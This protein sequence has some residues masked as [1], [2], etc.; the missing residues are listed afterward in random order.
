MPCV[1]INNV[2]FG[3]SF[4]TELL[5]VEILPSPEGEKTLPP[6]FPGLDSLYD[7][8]V[9]AFTTSPGPELRVVV[10]F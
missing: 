3:L 10:R 2:P 6:G 9:F 8:N 7:E 5:Q 4:V 1:K